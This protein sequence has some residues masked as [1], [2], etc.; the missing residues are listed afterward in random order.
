MQSR[1]DER[2]RGHLQRSPRFPAHVA[3]PRAGNLLA[4]DRT[5]LARWFTKTALLLAKAHD[6]PFLAH[7]RGAAIVRGMPEDVEVFIARRRR[8]P[9][10]LDFWLDR[11]GDGEARSVAIVVDDV[12]GRVAKRGTLAGA[13]GT[14]LWP[15]RTHTLRF[16]T[17][18]VITGFAAAPRKA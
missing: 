6:A 9:Q 10:P 14:Q 3:R 13:H 2:P 17:L 5:T 15:L 7:T 18:P 8:A 1:L 4:P 11:A 12:V 16:D